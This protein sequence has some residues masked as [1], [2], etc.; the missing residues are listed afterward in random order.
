MKKDS[1][2]GIVGYG[3]EGRSTHDY[4]KKQG[5][6][7]I[8]ILDENETLECDEKCILGEKIWEC[9]NDFDVLFRSPGIHPRRVLKTFQGKLSSHME[10]FFEKC[11]VPII[12]I[13]GTKGKG[14][15]SSLTQKMIE[16]SGKKCFLGGNIGM[17]PLD[18]LDEIQAN[19]YVVLEV[20]S[21]Q[22]MT[23]KQSPHIA[24]ILM[25]TSEHL[26]Y[27]KD[28]QEYIDAKAQ[29]LKNQRED[30]YCIYHK[31]F[32]SSKYIASLS[33]ARKLG[34]S[35]QSFP[36]APQQVGAT[37]DA[38]HD[39]QIA[40]PGKHNLNN[41]AAAVEVVKILNISDE[42]IKEV[43]KTFTGLPMHIEKISEKN[44]IS[45]INDSFSTTPETT[46]AALDSFPEKNIVV[47][48][49][50]S[51]KGSDY[52]ELLDYIILCDTVFPVFY[53]EEGKVLSEKITQ[54]KS[55]DY[56]KDFKQAF[57][58]AQ[59]ILE[60]KNGGVLLLSPACASFDQFKNYKERGEKFNTFIYAS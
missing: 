29:M 26:D 23:F 44:G 6:L 8:T 50:G 42:Y 43:L 9:L 15:T 49:G 13:T 7:N 16:E 32:E 59:S 35:S 33:Q 14:T 19:D 48:I 53:G 24:V 41:I 47:M 28:T 22:A 27:H 40:L 1:K 60:E 4:L 21:F 5:F 30:D 11:P 2:I 52:S 36:L 37:C 46:L 55:V 56:V 3:V 34:F 38:F 10:F 25:V 57:L 31:D 51:S 58:K 20:S 54:K 39:C 45:Y 18:F 17:P 12:S